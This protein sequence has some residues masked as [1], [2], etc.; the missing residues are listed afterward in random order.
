MALSLELLLSFKLSCLADELSEFG[1][2][3]VLF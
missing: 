1:K 3:V 2:N